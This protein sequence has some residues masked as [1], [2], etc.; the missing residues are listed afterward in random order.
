ACYLF[1]FWFR[2]ADYNDARL[3]LERVIALPEAALFP[4]PYSAALCYLA[5]NYWLQT[6][7]QK[8][9]P[10]VE[11]ALAVAQAHGDQHNVAQALRM[12]GQVLTNESDYAG[13]RR[14]Q[15]ESRALHQALGDDW[16]VSAQVPLAQALV[17]YF[18]QDWA[19]SL[20]LHA[21][22]LDGFRR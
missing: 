7:P 4:E 19:A 14:V 21:Q 1:W 3:W 5:N 10:L 12:L 17:P 2:R 20:A 18:E 8:A 11:K 6:G 9:H 15:A 22:A 16:N 13:A